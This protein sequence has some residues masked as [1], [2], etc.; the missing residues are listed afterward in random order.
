MFLCDVYQPQF[1]KIGLEAEDKDE[2]FE[3]LVDHFCEISN[4]NAREEILDAIRERE[5]KMSTGIYRGIAIPHGKTNA[6]DQIYGVLGL[7]RKGID[8]DALDGKP[9][10]ILFLILAPEKDS[11]K[12]LNLL[13]RL[14]EMLDNPQFFPDLTSQTSAQ[15]AYGILKKYEDILLTL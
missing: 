8:Y 11:E 13:K 3:E 6:V 9:V 1:I 15:A 14:A 4:I 7:S 12:H 10:Y 2:A 5:M